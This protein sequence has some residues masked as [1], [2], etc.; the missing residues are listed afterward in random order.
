MSCAGGQ[1]SL[2]FELSVIL[3]YLEGDCVI[4]P[5][6]FWCSSSVVGFY[7]QTAVLESWF[8]GFGPA[9]M[10]HCVSIVL[11]AGMHSVWVFAKERCVPHEEIRS[12]SHWNQSCSKRPF[13]FLL[14]HSQLTVIPP[15]FWKCQMTFSPYLLNLPL[16]VFLSLTL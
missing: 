12:L 6:C 11:S 13:Y 8:L 10:E 14:S 16:P 9:F 15:V 1:A 5:S 3:T 7:G 2:E 4:F